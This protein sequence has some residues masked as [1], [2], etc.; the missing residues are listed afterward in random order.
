LPERLPVVE[1][2]PDKLTVELVSHSPQWA[3]MAA[4]ETLR[5]KAALGDNLVTVHHIG[6]T[7]LHGIR[8]KPIVDLLPVVRSLEVLDA[9]ESAIRGL[10]YRWFGEFGLPGRRYCYCVDPETGKRVFQLHCYA[11]D[12]PEIT[13]HL[14]FRDYLL[15][16]PDIAIEYESEKIRAA[17]VRSDDVNAYNDEKNEWIKRVESDALAWRHRANS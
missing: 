1:D 13:R 9:R 8:A 6:S 7:A 15:A 12:N 2:K 17:S 16:H 5:L 14:A 11:Q 4:S 3:T 10:G